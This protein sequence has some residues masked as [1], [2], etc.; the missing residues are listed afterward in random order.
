MAYNSAAVVNAM[1]Q[2][3]T[4]VRAADDFR[5]GE[6]LVVLMGGAALGVFAGLG[7]ALALGRA[8]MWPIIAGVPLFVFALYLAVATC[9]DALERRAFGCATAAALVAASMLAWPAS[10]LF[11]PMSALV[12][13]LPPAAAVCSMALLA[14]CWSGASGAVYRLSGEAAMFCAIVGFLGINQIMG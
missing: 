13:W 7:A 2:G 14:S 12:F 4:A 6:R 11:V 1:G 5:R 9:R 3:A 8:G 10:A